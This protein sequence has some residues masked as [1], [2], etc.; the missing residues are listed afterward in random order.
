MDDDAALLQATAEGDA[1][2]FDR[3]YRRHLPVVVSFCRRAAGDP[4]LA[5]DLT[6]EVFATALSFAG[7]Y[8]PQ[9]TTASPWLIGIAHNKLRESL[10]RGR[11]QDAVR[12]RLQM[13]PLLLDD[14]R[15]QRVE[16]LAVL[17]SGELAALFEQLPPDE[18]EAIRARV[19]D[20]RDYDEIAASLRCSRSVVR[21]RVSRGLARMRRYLSASQTTETRP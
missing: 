12:R 16:E 13:S 1:D 5:A 7:R 15:L 20:E 4:E 17:G 19:I 11:V 10:R 18:R 8:R 6:A 21:Q 9:Q 3:F 2:A 14:E